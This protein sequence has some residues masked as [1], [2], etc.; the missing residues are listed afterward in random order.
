M[1]DPAASPAQLSQRPKIKN[2]E[3]INHLKAKQL[4]P[5]EFI[6]DLLAEFNGNALDLLMALIQ[7]GYG[8][9]Q[10]LCQIWCNTIGI[11]HVDLEKTLFQ[12]DVVRKLPESFAREY[13]A[14]PVYQMG[15]TITVAT[16]TPQNK[17]ILKEIEIRV[18]GR[19]NLVF[20][21]PQ[22]IEW[23]IEQEYM[24]NT[25]L[26]DFLKKIAASRVLISDKRI[27]PAGLKQIA[28]E[29]A[30]NQLHVAI[31]LVGITEN[32]SEIIIEPSAEDAR[33][34]FVDHQD[35]KER[36]LL[37][38]PVYRTLTANLIKL[39]KLDNTSADASQ[40]SRILFPTPGKKYDI[41]VL[42]LP[43]ETGQKL[44]LKLMD[45]QPLLRL[46]QLA[47]LY[48]S[49]K[50]QQFITHQLDMANGI[51]LM[52]GPDTAAQTAIAYAILLKFASGKGKY[53]TVEDNI[54]YLL[55]GIEQYQVNP[56]AGV[57]RRALL[58]SCL[59]QHPK[60][61]YIQNID[62][63]ELKDLLVG[64]NPSDQFIVAGIKAEN[65]VEA[66]YRALQM[67]M[68]NVVNAVVA[69][70]PAARLCDHCKEKYI[71]PE[72]TVQELFI[73]KEKTRVSAWRE[74]GCAY[75]SHTGFIGSIGIY[76]YLPAT[77]VLKDLAEKNTNRYNLHQKT[78]EYNY[79]SLEYDG[80]KKVLRGLTPLKE[81]ERIQ[82][83][84]IS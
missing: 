80:I 79:E 60:M 20:A 4:L 9:K 59:K 25:S 33:V 19:V 50:L 23:A 21:L 30:I 68:G 73:A 26:Q 81:L 58:E 27:T 53:L 38:L 37:D 69:Q 76:E 78:K 12:P 43:T 66:L 11:A 71:L 54:K 39:A 41:R 65:A 40:Y 83:R 35:I 18:G 2:P 74:A 5:E 6:E 16:A 44:F 77:S 72:E 61:I 31:T 22:D 1:T 70:Q 42:S 55:N 28:G 75:C 8:S 84:F 13:Y 62:D 51:F 47:N 15:D 63:P 10:D 48:M 56:E 3:F 52:G 7:T 46:P 29:E 49:K 64:I 24:T 45:R 34:Y 67:G 32:I 82:S 36:F 14:I 57:T 17:K